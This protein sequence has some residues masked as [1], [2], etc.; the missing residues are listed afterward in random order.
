MN[1]ILIVD[2]ETQI[3]EILEDF[4]VPKGFKIE[5]AYNGR[6]GLEILEK[7]T[8]VD[9]II[10]DEKMPE[11]SGS[12]FREGLKELGKNIPVIVLTGSVGIGQKEHHDSKDIKH[13]LFKPVRLS[14]LLDLMKKIL[15]S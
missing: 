15:A 7:D 5:K 11:V 6:E 4:L 2:D 1:T 12:G 8:P 9:L 10:L 13:L 3:V 14:E